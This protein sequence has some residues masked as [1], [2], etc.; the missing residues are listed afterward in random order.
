ML[1]NNALFFKSYR[2]IQH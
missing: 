1:R 2:R